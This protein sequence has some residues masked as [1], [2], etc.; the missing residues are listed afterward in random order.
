MQDQNL[1]AEI[2]FD[3]LKPVEVSVTLEG[4]K[5]ILREATADVAVQYRNASFRSFRMEDGKLV[6]MDGL[7]DI[8]P[9]VV[10]LCLCRCDGDGKVRLDGKGNVVTVL[11]SD[12]RGWK[13]EVMKTLFDRIKAISPGLEEKLPQETMEKTFRELAIKLAKCS[14]SSS[15][16]KLWREFF[17]SVV[18]DA[19]IHAPL[20]DVAKNGSCAG[21]VTSA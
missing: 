7:A 9:L 13:V 10:S 2:V 11:E 8:E 4:V 18:N 17:E 21:T 5:W 6:R 1:L 14:A 15:D 16:K 20:E 19:M 12:I 3:S